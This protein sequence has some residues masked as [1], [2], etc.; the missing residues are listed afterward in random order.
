[1]YAVPLVELPPKSVVVIAPVL[2]FKEQLAWLEFVNTFVVSE[3]V[4]AL[5][6]L[7]ATV[8]TAP[9]KSPAIVPNEPAL[10]ENVGAVDAVKIL[11]ELLPALPSG[12]S[13]LTK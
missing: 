9:E 10:V 2:G 4:T 8:A 5:S 6:E 7:A 1:M 11:F 13:T 12:F 3:N